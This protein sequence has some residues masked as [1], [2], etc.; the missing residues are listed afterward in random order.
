MS[1]VHRLIV[2]N[3]TILFCKCI[4]INMSQSKNVILINL[5]WPMILR[6]SSLWLWQ[7]EP[8]H[9]QTCLPYG[10]HSGL[11]FRSK[12][13]ETSC[14]SSDSIRAVETPVSPP[15]PIYW[16]SLYY[17]SSITSTEGGVAHLKSGS[18]VVFSRVHLLVD[19]YHG[20]D[21]FR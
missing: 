7:I 20:L 3:V 2:F 15:P 18:R 17:I 4:I 6:R 21:K 11:L 14:F 12:H 10:G 9:P 1:G 13:M 5:C 16:K 19:C 8:C